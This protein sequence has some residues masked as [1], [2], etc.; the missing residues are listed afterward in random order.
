MLAQRFGQID[1]DG[2]AQRMAINEALCGIGL[3]LYQ[4]LPGNVRVFVDRRFRGR[5]TPA[6]SEAAVVDGQHGKAELPQLL[7]AKQ[8]A[9]EVPA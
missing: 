9:G 1:G 4:P 5:L 7:D 3:Q 8:L 6:L 2:A